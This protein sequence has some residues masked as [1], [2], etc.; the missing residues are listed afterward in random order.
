MSAWK[1][2]SGLGPWTAFRGVA[3]SCDGNTSC[4]A[5]IVASF[6]SFAHF[7]EMELG[8]QRTSFHSKRE[9]NDKTGRD[10]IISAK[11]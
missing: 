7:T 11:S 1:A 9:K 3:G 5:E 2:N 6:L 10:K 8:N 4:S